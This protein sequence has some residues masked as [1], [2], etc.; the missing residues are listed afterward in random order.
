[1]ERANRQ[2]LEVQSSA[3]LDLG[4]ERLAEVCERYGVRTLK[5]FGSFA[6]GEAT[7]KSDIDLLVT[8]VRPVGFF[9]LVALERE[10]SR[11][12]GRRVDLVTE[13]ALSPYI[14]D[15]VMKAARVVW[16]DGRWEGLGVAF[17]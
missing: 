13:G 6:R 9:K 3:Q 10:L 4:V 15:K 8:F 5:V 16:S 14:R 11:L 2:S 12:L 17:P 1:M 7:E